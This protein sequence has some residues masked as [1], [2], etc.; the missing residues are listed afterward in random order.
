M[1]KRFLAVAAAATL[2]LGSVAGCSTTT[3][4][5]GASSPSA[6][7][8]AIDSSVDNAL[9]RLY[10]Q[11]PSARGLVA[12]AKGTLVFPT[13]LTAGLV[14]GGSYGQGSLVL[15]RQRDK[16]YNMVGGAVGLIAGAESKS[17]YLLFMTQEALDKFQ[18]SKGWTAGVDAS[19]TVITV[20]AD[21][22]IGTKTAQ[23]DII[24]FVL[25]NG[26]LMAN[27]SVQGTKFSPI[28][29]S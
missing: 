18:A 14:V 5:A 19:V 24:G 16:Y 20:A 4:A 6:K 2:A 21:A 11:V 15:P 26:G 9:A 22:Q 27:A 25:T 28:D 23:Q 10:A 7:R 17:V 3:S 29:I 8:Q 13:V 1:N 12:Q